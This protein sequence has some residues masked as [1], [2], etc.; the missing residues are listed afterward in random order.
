MDPCTPCALP[1]KQDD[2]R[3]RQRTP[4]HQNASPSSSHPRAL[5]SEAEVQSLRRALLTWYDAHHRTLPWRRTPPTSTSTYSLTSDAPSD[6]SP[7]DFAYRVWV[8]EIMLQQTRV[9]TVIDY[10]T[11]WTQKWPTVQHLAGATQEEVNEMWAGLG[12]YRRA[13]YL[14]E[15]AKYITVDCQGVFPD[16]YEQLLKVPG[17]GPYTAAAVA[18][19]AYGQ[20]VAVVDWNVQRV[21]SRLRAITGDVKTR[22]STGGYVV[23]SSRSKGLPS[24]YRL[25]THH[26]PRS[27]PLAPVHNPQEGCRGR[28]AVRVRSR[29][30]RGLQ[31]GLHGAG[32]DLVRSP[33]HPRV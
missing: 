33:G 32:G 4:L 12:Y 14:L 21:F 1:R 7:S 20:R 29:P 6:L 19:I 30:P 16:T 3:S 15:G 18:S 28:G 8:S 2:W 26:T 9:A 11:T 10:F 22:T 23:S 17:I 27:L 13:R 25:S 24:G 31:S 5:W